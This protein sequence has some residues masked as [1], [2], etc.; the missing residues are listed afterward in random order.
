MFTCASGN[1][2]LKLLPVFMD[3]ILHPI[4]TPETVDMEVFSLK[5]DSTSSSTAAVVSAQGVVYCEMKGR[6]HSE[7]DLM[8]FWLRRGIAAKTADSAPELAR[9]TFECGGLTKDITTLSCEE[10][11]TFHQ[12]FYVPAKMTVLLAGRIT[13]QSIEELLASISSTLKE[14]YPQDTVMPYSTPSNA[15]LCIPASI[16]FPADD[17]SLGSVGLAWLGADAHDLITVLSYHVLFK[18][19]RETSSS[20]LHQGLVQIAQ[21]W[22][23]EIDYEIKPFFRTIMTLIFSGVPTEKGLEARKIAQLVKEII[24]E[25]LN[26]PQSLMKAIKL[27]LKAFELKM[28]ELLEDDPHEIVSSY[29]IPNL[30]YSAIFPSSSMLPFGAN[31]CQLKGIVRELQSKSVDYWIDLMHIFITIEPVEVLLR[32]DLQMNQRIEQEEQELLQ[33]LRG[34]ARICDPES[35]KVNVQVDCGVQLMTDASMTPFTRAGQVICLPTTGMKSVIWL[36]NFKSSIP[37]ALWPLL[38]LFQE[39]LFQCDVQLDSKWLNLLGMN[40]S[41]P[42]A[43]SYQSLQKALNA[44]FNSY[45]IS[46]GL[47]NEIFSVGYCEEAQLISAVLLDSSKLSLEE[48]VGLLQAIL[49]GTIFTVER[50]KIVA[51]NLSNQIRDLQ[52]DAYEVIDAV[53]TAELHSLRQAE[54]LVELK[55]T[56]IDNPRVFETEISI[57]KQKALLKGVMD[58]ET[59]VLEG[60][61]T[62]QEAI[63]FDQAY[64]QC[65]GHPRVMEAERSLAD[66]SVTHPASLFDLKTLPKFGK[67]SINEP[68]AIAYPLGD[69]TASYLSCVLPCNILP[70]SESSRHEA[71]LKEYA[72][73]SLLCHLLSITEGPI[74]G[75][76]RGRGLAYGAHLTVSLWNGL[77]TFAVD[78]STGPAEAFFVF[79]QLMAEVDECFSAE[80]YG[81]LISEEALN[82]AKS[83]LIFQ[84]IEE[85][86]T[87]SSLQTVLLRS[88]LRG[89]PMAASS[90]ADDPVL[91]CIKDCQLLDLKAA[92][93]KYFGGW[94]ETKECLVVLVCPRATF[95]AA[96]QEFEEKCGFRFEKKTFASYCEEAED[97]DSSDD[98]DE[99][100]GN[101]EDNSEDNNGEENSEEDVNE[102]FPL[103]E[104]SHDDLE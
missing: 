74:Y 99:E 11:V 9:F 87:P 21:P 38:P 70:V 13:E 68:V 8:D 52:K 4:I 79:K 59:G 66:K 71:S 72:S 32:P 19:L 69:I 85:R 45:C 94:R 25:L 24:A 17:A 77:L 102:H 75:R 100:E 84:L 92:W 76:I 103:H 10:I 98:D 35:V 5:Q 41:L 47:E 53:L 20:P 29:T 96:V 64:I 31:V 82:V 104:S 43:V 67:L 27:T 73:I 23:T 101:E 28:T 89:I 56:K 93:L 49:K 42:T 88:S 3:H 63:S 12:Q 50:V 33:Q 48:A 95:E 57:F 81:S 39:L 51:E 90:D 22:A 83:A 80:G 1:G 6:Q 37:Q 2:L 14:S 36:S 40:P 7:A 30:T 58:S 97:E 46:F 55:R 91:S 15:N 86:S 65:G 18:Y 54:P 61:K 16:P 60:L 62:I 44:N 34:N 78:D 26:S